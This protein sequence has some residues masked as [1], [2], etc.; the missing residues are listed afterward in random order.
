MFAGLPEC[1]AITR[2]IT[3]RRNANGDVARILTGSVTGQRPRP[4]VTNVDRAPFGPIERIEFQSGRSIDYLLDASYQIIEASGDGLATGFD[5]DPAGNILN[6]IAPATQAVVEQYG[7]DSVYRLES[8]SDSSSALIEAFTY[9]SIGNRQSR[10]SAS[11]TVPYGY[12]PDTHRFTS[13][14]TD[15]RTFDAIGNTVS[16]DS[17]LV[18][19][20][21]DDRGRLV[22]VQSPGID[23]GM[24]ASYVI[25]GLGQR[26]RKT[27]HTQT[28]DSTYFLYDESGRLMGEYKPVALG[29]GL[30]PWREYIWLDDRVVGVV[31]E[32]GNTHE[33][34][35]D[36]LGTPRAILDKRGQT[37][38]EWAF[39]RN[40]FGTR[41]PNEDPS[42]LRSPFEF[43]LRFPGQY[44][45]AE[46]GLHYNY[47]R[48]YEPG[49]GRYVQS[50]P[51]GLGGGTNTYGYVSMHPLSSIDFF[52]L[53]GS[54]WRALTFA[55][56]EAIEFADEQINFW[57]NK[58]RKK[59]E[60][61]FVNQWIVNYR[62]CESSLSGLLERAQ[63]T[64][65]MHGSFDQEQYETDRCEIETRCEAI[66]GQLEFEKNQCLSNVGRDLVPLDGLCTIFWLKKL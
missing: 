13:V 4:F 28:S 9:D 21:Y 44:Y 38:W 2:T 23:G 47:F 7:Y 62:S 61:I 12:Q 66:E 11:G 19:F 59:C 39:D 5:R 3:Y 34:Y 22:Q 30:E 14:G 52:G 42:G 57:K 27:V 33:V 54:Q 24:T 40:A 50:D 56:C 51:I 41:P 43:N 32:F 31:D 63:H 48:D 10:T 37:R 53:L 60:I 36:H 16:R 29:L 46:S 20:S 8:V 49:V 17:G 18:Q 15:T 25:N 55:A 45:D 65:F 26:V 6:L 58:R 35:T 64:R 1:P